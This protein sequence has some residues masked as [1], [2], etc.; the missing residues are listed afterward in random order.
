M[1]IVD[2]ISEAPLQS[3]AGG[4]GKAAGGVANTLGKASGVVA[5][6]VPAAAKAAVS[7]YKQGYEKMD[8]VLSVLKG[9]QPKDN[10]P[11]DIDR[12]TV[13]NRALSGQMLNYS[14]VKSVQTLI[15][16]IQ[17]GTIKTNQNPNYLVKG[18]TAAAN[19][20]GVPANLRPSIEAF[21]DEA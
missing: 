12:E 21:R 7:G 6:T 17:D 14:D 8:K 16:G 19:G 18:L 2:V 1:R 5:G 15:K 20:Q 11:K 3:V 13:L 10:D 4:V 9:K